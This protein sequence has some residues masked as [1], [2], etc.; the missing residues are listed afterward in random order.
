MAFTIAVHSRGEYKTGEP[1]SCDVHVITQNEVAHR[2]QLT[3]KHGYNY[4][5]TLK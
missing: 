4:L 2:P 5:F 3:Q 1:A